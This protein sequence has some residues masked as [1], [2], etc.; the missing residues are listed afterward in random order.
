MVIAKNP[1]LVEIH[2][3]S[4]L[5]SF[6]VMDFWRPNHREAAYVDGKLSIDVY[7]RSL[8]ESYADFRRKDD[9]PR[10]IIACMR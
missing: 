7:L 8:R 3:Q 6:D 1:S 2:P 4:G 5:F 10:S 9:L